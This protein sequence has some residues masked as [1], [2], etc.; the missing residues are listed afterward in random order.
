ML[1]LKSI[2]KHETLK[3]WV[4]FFRVLLLRLGKTLKIGKLFV[5]NLADVQKG[6][7]IFLPLSFAK[8]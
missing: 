1:F 7:K 5:T 8:R 6:D 4:T 2:L 3:L